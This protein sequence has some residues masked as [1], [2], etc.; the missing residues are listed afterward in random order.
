MM[1]LIMT[2][3]GMT[4]YLARGVAETFG[5]LYPLVSPF[6]GAL[7]TFITGSNTNSNVMFGMMQYETAAALGKSAV[8]IAASQSVGASVSV[9]ISPSTIMT[10]AANVG[11][12]HGGENKIMAGTIRYW[13]FNISLVGFIVWM[14]GR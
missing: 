3:S 14:F 12:G 5:G 4:N 7:G 1:A 8:L 13:F 10:G 6:I 9:S 2:D 11:I